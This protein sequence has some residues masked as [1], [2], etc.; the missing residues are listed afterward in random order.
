M[1]LRPVTHNSPR[2]TQKSIGP[3]KVDLSDVKDVIDLL[4]DN[5]QSIASIKVGK[6]EADEVEDFIDASA[7]DLRDIEITATSPDI[8]V[9]LTS[10]G[11]HAWTQDEEPSTVRLV[12]QIAEMLNKG[13]F[14]RKICYPWSLLIPLAIMLVLMGV[15]SANLAI[16]DHDYKFGYGLF[17]VAVISFSFFLWFVPRTFRERGAVEFIPLWRRERRSTSMGLQRTVA[18]N[19][20]G[21]TAGAV[22]GF[23]SALAMQW[24]KKS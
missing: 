4:R 6:Y 2:L 20:V 18:T 9:V 10:D 1:P 15:E 7:Q 22:L 19:L 13:D 23:L 12:E 3:V 24:I 21:V 14:S 17:G 16:G 5:C 8:Q 11:A